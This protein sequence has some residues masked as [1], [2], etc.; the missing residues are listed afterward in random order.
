MPNSVFSSS[1]SALTGVLTAGVAAMH[2]A[3]ALFTQAPAAGQPPGIA[4][5]LIKA[6]PGIVVS[7]NGNSVVFADGSALPLDDGKGAKPF[8]AWLTEPDIED[9]FL[10]VYPAGDV[11]SPPPADFDPGRARNEAFFTKVYGDCRKGEVEKSL[12]DV[13]WLPK[14]SGTKLKVSTI[15]GAADRLEAVS[16]ELD[17]MPSH[18][19][20]DLFPVAGTYNCRTIAGTTSLSAHGLGIAID[21]ALAHSNYWRWEKPAADGSITYRNAIPLEIVRIFEK[22][23]FIWGGKWHH[24]DTMHFE[25]RP[26]LLM[27][28]E[29]SASPADPPGR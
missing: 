11:T 5:R 9:M 7:V 4:E 3:W 1:H 29:E 24:F 2:L 18:F 13:I 8:A 20:A 6:Y 16:R 27:P 17:A 22:H 26:E 21:I 14:K 23:G 12:A 28:A 10:Q 19:D 15:N 25:Y